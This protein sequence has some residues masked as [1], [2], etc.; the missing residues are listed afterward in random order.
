MEQPLLSKQQPKTVSGDSKS[1][2]KS[3]I[4]CHTLCLC[5][6][7]LSIGLIVAISVLGSHSGLSNQSPSRNLN[8]KSGKKDTADHIKQK[9]HFEK[10]VEP[11]SEHMHFEWEGTDSSFYP[12]AV[13]VDVTRMIIK[14][15]TSTASEYYKVDGADDLMEG[16]LPGLMKETCSLSPSNCG[17]KQ[18]SGYLMANENREIH[19]WLIESEVDPENKPVM[20]WTN[21]IYPLSLS[22]SVC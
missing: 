9:N 20:I 2:T 6:A 11:Q 10:H 18:Y 12:T 19:Y 7:L 21:G 3:P 16:D 4:W 22:L 15:D 13:K 14:S 8:R 17:F 1:R 5:S